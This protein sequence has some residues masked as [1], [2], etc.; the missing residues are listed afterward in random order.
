MTREAKRIK[1][2]E[3]G[4]VDQRVRSEL[5]ATPIEDK[6]NSLVFRGMVGRNRK[7]GSRHRYEPRK[8]FSE[9]P[10]RSLVQHPK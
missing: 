8:I 5:K 3:N 1:C 7:G 4:E 2:Q 9:I 10:L 6:V